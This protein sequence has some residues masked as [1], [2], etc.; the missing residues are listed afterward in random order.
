MTRIPV[1]TDPKIAWAMALD[2]GVRSQMGPI[3]EDLH[4]GGGIQYSVKGG[5]GA[6]SGVEYW[7]I[8]SRI[9]R[10]EREQPE[11]AAI[12]HVLCHPDTECRNSYLDSAAETIENR[13]IALIPNWSDGRAWKEA[14]KERVPYLIRVALMERSLNLS[15]EQPAWR[16]ERIGAIMAEWYGMSIV[17]RDWSRD[18][19]PA[20][21]VIQAVI[22]H[23]EADAIEPISDVIGDIVQRVRRVA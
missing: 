15:N 17:T 7:P 2:T 11:L 19:L 16:P 14:K 1:V 10:M 23:M 21:A 4:N 8:L 12:G 9:L 3:L 22:D 6:S 5:A 13:V 20:W 18:W